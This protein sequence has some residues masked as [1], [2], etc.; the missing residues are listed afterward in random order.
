MSSFSE[1]SEL[2]ERNCYASWRSVIGRQNEY[3]IESVDS[4]VFTMQDKDGEWRYSFAIR[5]DGRW[6]QGKAS[7]LP[8]SY[9]IFAPND[10]GQNRS[11]ENVASDL[12]FA[13]LEEISDGLR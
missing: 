12:S 2:M 3:R 9:D 1:F 4:T 11:P 13:I 5:S 6:Y 8:V 10:N 7:T